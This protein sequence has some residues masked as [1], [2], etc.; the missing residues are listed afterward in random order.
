MLFALSLRSVQLSD[1]LGATKYAL[2]RVAKHALPIS[3][4]PENSSET[5]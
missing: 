5:R 1:E 2:R 4:M 3:P